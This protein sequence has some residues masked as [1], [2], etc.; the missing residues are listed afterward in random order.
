M[1][2]TKRRKIACFLGSLLALTVAAAPAQEQ[3]APPGGG[4]EKTEAVQAQPEKLPAIEVVGTYETAPTGSVITQKDLTTGPA[5]DL[6]GFLDE[7][8]GIDLTRR[9]LMGEKNRQ[10]QIRGLDES[11]YQ[12]YL[13]GRSLKGAGVF[14]GYFVDW[15]TLSLAGLERVE[16][17]R[18]AQSAEYGNTLGGII[19]ITTAK[20]S[21]E[22]KLAVDASYGSW[23]TQNYRLAH[24]GGYGPVEYALVASF[25]KSSGYLRNNFIDP[26]QNYMGSFTYHFPWDMSVTLRGRYSG[27]KTGMI[28]ANRPFLPFFRPN[29][30]ESDGDILFGP[31]VPFW[32][33]KPGPGGGPGYDY[34][35]NSFVNRRR[36]DLDLS[37]KQKL[38][39]GEVEANLFYF[40]TFRRDRFF[41]LNNSELLV[42]ERHSL[43]EDTWGWNLK[44]RQ[45][46]GKVRLGFGLEGNYY[47]YGHLTNDFFL[48]A[49]FRF[50]PS[51][52]PANKNAQKIHGGFV[53]ALIPLAK[54]A[55]LYLGLRYDNYDAA[56]NIDPSQNLFVKGIRKDY[57]SPK[58]TLTFRPTETTEG[59]V[60]VN[61][62]SRFPTLPEFYWFGAGYRP[63][64]RAESLSP[65]FG[66]Q[67]E[68]GLTQK[69]PFNS[70]LRVRGYYYDINQYIRTVFGFRPSRVIY[71]IDLAKIRGV[72]VEAETT[73][74]YHLTA[75]ANYTWQQTSTSP[76]PLG[77]DV[78]ELTEFPDHKV[79]LGLKYRAPNGAEGK[80][81]VRL[82][83]KRAEPVVKVNNNQVTGVTLRP[84]KG[85]FTVNLEGR[86]TVANWRGFTG[87]LYGGVYNLTGEFYEE[88][89]GFP[90]PTQTL[91]GGVQLRY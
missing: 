71:N 70:T 27:Q 6:P 35:D 26:A 12:V 56:A 48:P 29:E 82:V 89:A 43:D 78:R 52:S 22:P 81:Y 40:Q 64:H 74:P 5:Q 88:S 39:H 80:C 75:F 3:A 42:L 51:S 72:E 36:F 77:G 24:T 65:E 66:L 58:S 73:L 19:K 87:F 10:V 57:L 85:F 55:E 8:S 53:D 76:D 28:V 18:G 4:E 69:L 32:G 91:Y 61:F 25:A 7:Q 11:R 20:G 30:P 83:S 60:S 49:Y 67:Y 15:S 44:T 21:K 13:D 47:G 33:F 31:G 63:P 23:D 17:I 46:L 14:G 37:V 90:L 38:W 86:Y 68:A 62:A 54:W 59:Y 79:N 16:I 84:M 41:A 1:K 45:T 9:S 2:W 34:G 50:P